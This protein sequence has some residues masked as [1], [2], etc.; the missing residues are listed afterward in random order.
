MRSPT[1]P[2]TFCEACGAVVDISS[3][4][5]ATPEPRGHFHYV[6]HFVGCPR[7]PRTPLWLAVLSL[8]GYFRVHETQLEADTETY[9]VRKNCVRGRR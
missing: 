2:P 3:T 7:S 9:Y 4:P 5:S 6:K 1:H 8:C